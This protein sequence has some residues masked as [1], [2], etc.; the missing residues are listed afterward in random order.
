MWLVWGVAL[1]STV[2]L[3]VTIGPLWR[4]LRSLRW[5][6][7]VLAAFGI[8]LALGGLGFIVRF[9]EPAAGP[10]R[11]NELYPF[12][13]YVNAW[14]VSFGFMWLGFGLLFLALALYAPHTWRT[15]WLLFLAWFLAWLPHGI[16]GLGFAIA[17][18]NEPSIRVYRDWASDWPGF[19]TLSAGAAVLLT[20]FGLC[21]VGFAATALSLRGES[22]HESVA[23]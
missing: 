19:V 9:W 12:G 14:A 13:P 15:W 22:R 11:A 4:P 5:S 6:W 10:Y 16:I 20:H 1:L 21:A 7:R 18:S 8:P 23:A 17:G 3:A 2:L